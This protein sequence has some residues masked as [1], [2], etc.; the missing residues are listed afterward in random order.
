VEVVLAFVVVTVV[1]LALLRYAALGAVTICVAEVRD[2]R[3][4]V[5]RGGLA[6]RLLADLGD[7]VARPPVARATVR[8]VR[9]R[10]V[11]EIEMKGEM[12]AEQRQ[13]VRNVIGSV[14]MAML[15]NARRRR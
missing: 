14:P 13:R 10:G 4:E 6:P 15:A 7:V 2:G 3:I 8:I 11:A 1:A 9:A 12:S 5:T